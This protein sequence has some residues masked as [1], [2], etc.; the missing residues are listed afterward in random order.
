M[1]AKMRGPIVRTLCL[2]A[3]AVLTAHP[4]PAHAATPSVKEL[5]ARVDQHYNRLHSLEV[6]FVQTYT[7]MGLHKREAG[8]L[9]LKK[10]GRMRWTYTQP[11]G[12]LYVLDGRFGYFYTPGQTEA[13]KVP[14]KK[15]DGL[16]SPLRY[17]LG[18][19]ELM[20]E[21]PDLHIAADENGTYTL[22]GV[23]RGMQ[24]S[25]SGVTLK[26][27][28]EGYIREI[29]V[30]QTDGIVNELNFSG[31]TDNIPAPNSAFVFHPPAGVYVVNSLTPME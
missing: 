25:I 6:A 13:Q 12:K 3:C 31:E 21:M 18:H 27:T 8:A 10:P 7:G 9:L 16:Q 28:A 24:K 1:S 26:V 23:P 4:M 17:L 22:V 15:L 29:R 5:A 11:D 2:A 14:A 19:T 30:A 20:R